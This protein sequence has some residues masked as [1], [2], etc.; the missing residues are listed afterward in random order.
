[1]REQS[2]RAPAKLNLFLHVLGRRSDGYHLLESLVVFTQLADILHIAPAEDL[3][4]T[5]VG[6]FASAAGDTENNLVMKAARLLQCHAATGQGARLTLE[7]NIPVGAGLGGGS[8][9]AAA[10]LRGLQQLWQLALPSSA[11][12]AIAVTLGADVPMCLAAQPAIASGIGDTLLPIPHALPAMSALLVHPRVPLL[13]AQVYKA[14]QTIQ[15]VAPWP[16]TADTADAF[17]QALARTG[18]HLQRPAIA[19]DA[20]V[21]E[22]LLAIETVQP[23]PRIARM[24]GSG[25]CCFGLYSDHEEAQRAAQALAAQHPNWWVRAERI[26]TQGAAA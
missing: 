3:S 2:L 12:H 24:T 17:W 1:M 5:V 11:L 25:A 14:F 10:T 6:E 4:L 22:V 15:S 26:V 21:A 7:K 13:T 23:S 16:S 9:D 19:V 8:A 20:T 18:N